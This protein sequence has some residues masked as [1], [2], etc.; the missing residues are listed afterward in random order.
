MVVTLLGKDSCRRVPPLIRIHCPP[1]AWSL[2]PWTE[3]FVLSSQ[4]GLLSLS[5]SLLVSAFLFVVV[6]VGAVGSLQTTVDT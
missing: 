5:L 1:M 6:Q 2:T 3:S 4:M